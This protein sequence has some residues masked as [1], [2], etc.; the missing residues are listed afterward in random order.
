MIDSNQDFRYNLGCACSGPYAQRLLGMN[1]EL[2]ESYEK[3]LLEDERLDRVH[4]RRG[5][6]E[7]SQFEVL[8]PGFTRLSLPW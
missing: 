1:H 8:R 4:L 3:L 7:Y 2:A 6:S 5:H